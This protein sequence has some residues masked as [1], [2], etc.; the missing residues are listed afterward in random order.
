[1]YHRNEKVSLFY[2]EIITDTQ[3]YKAHFLFSR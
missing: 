1:V 3:K 2:Y